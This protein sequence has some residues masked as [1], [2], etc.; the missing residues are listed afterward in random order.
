MSVFLPFLTVFVL[1]L[2]V[3]V[4][5]VP[6]VEERYLPWSSPLSICWSCISGSLRH[7]GWGL[8]TTSG[9]S[10]N[11]VIVNLLGIQHVT[12]E[13]LLTIIIFY[14]LEVHMYMSRFFLFSHSIGA[15]SLLWTKYKHEI[16]QFTVVDVRQGKFLYIAHFSSKAIQRVLHK[17]L[18]NN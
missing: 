3:Q 8:V 1:C 17:T 18:K 9:F 14:F 6:P 11:L 4:S 2:R 15:F 16:V 13:F 7:T 5:P 12:V 10:L